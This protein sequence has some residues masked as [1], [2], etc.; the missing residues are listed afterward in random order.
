MA[1]DAVFKRTELEQ[2][3]NIEARLGNLAFNLD[4]PRTRGRAPAFF[5]G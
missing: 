3:F 5:D 2:R 1:I 4:D